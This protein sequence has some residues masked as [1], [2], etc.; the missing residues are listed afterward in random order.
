MKKIIILSLLLTNIFIHSVN[1]VDLDNKTVMAKVGDY[2]I[3]A[4][5]MKVFMLGYSSVEK[6]LGSGLDKV[7]D[8]MIENLLFLNACDE[9]K[10][11]VTQTE[12]DYYMDKF[13]RDKSL[14]RRDLKAIQLY[15]DQNDPY[16][17]ADD[18]YR[19]SYLYLSK[20][21][22]LS[23]NDYLKS[24]KSYN[25]FFSTKGLD[26]KKKDSLRDQVTSLTREIAEGGPYF[27]DMVKTY[28]Q[29]EKS[30]QNRGDIGL[31]EMDKKSVD[32]FGKVGTER[33]IKAGLFNPIF[34]ESNSGFH[35]V[36]NYEYVMPKDTAIIDEVDTKLVNKFKITRNFKQNI[37]SSSTQKIEITIT[38]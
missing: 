31:V 37:E 2:E 24:C 26:K 30:K 12:V 29:D 23:Y 8:I 25:I 20:I 18:F 17:D 21:K 32:M 7:L 10:I 33:I 38:H 1:F 6:W 16:A 22:Y 4:G 27:F 36:M 28:S 5:D 9:Q 34:V 14:D 15:F 19:K 13:L 35:I 3:T 11:A